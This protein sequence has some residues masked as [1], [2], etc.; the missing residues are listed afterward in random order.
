[1]PVVHL[2]Y[3]VDKYCVGWFLGEGVTWRTIKMVESKVAD[4]LHMVW[5]FFP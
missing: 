1:M 2:T 4:R 3:D 5:K